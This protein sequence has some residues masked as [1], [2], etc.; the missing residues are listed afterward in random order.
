MK[1]TKKITA[2]IAATIILSVSAATPALAAPN[3]GQLSQS[4]DGTT[5]C[6]LIYWFPGCWARW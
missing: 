4:S 1:K 5:A 3:A 6:R 2:T